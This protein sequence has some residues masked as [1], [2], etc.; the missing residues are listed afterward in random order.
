MVIRN[1]MS[2]KMGGKISEKYG[3]EENDRQIERERGGRGRRKNDKGW[4]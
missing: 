2:Q 1:Q 4:R 3:K